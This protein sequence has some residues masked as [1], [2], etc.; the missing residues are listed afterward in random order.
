MW[1]FL[2]IALDHKHEIRD[3]LKETP[4]TYHI[5]DEGRDIA[6]MYRIKTYPTNLVLDKDGKVIFHS[7]GTRVNTPYWIKQ[8][9]MEAINSSQN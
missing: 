6:K 7:T 2:A 8:T 9:I 4:F 5:I 3:F 1:F